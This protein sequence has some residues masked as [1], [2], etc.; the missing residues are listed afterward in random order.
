MPEAI[1]ERRVHLRVNHPRLA[2]EELAAAIGMTP[3][4]S[5]RVGEPRTTPKGRLLPGVNRETYC[6]FEFAS[7]NTADVTDP[8]VIVA[9][10]LEPHKRAFLEVASTGGQTELYVTWEAHS[11]IGEVFGWE[12]L[13]KLVELRIALAVEWFPLR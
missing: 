6:V 13:S 5:W 10:F 3:T 8:G 2:P 12:F 4:R 7:E 1:I 9:A 11:N